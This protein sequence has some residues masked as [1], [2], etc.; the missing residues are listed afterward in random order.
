MATINTPAG[1]TRNGRNLRILAD[2]AREISTGLGARRNTYGTVQLVTV[3]QMHEGAN[4]AAHVTVKYRDG[5]IGQACFQDVTIAKQWAHGF[6]TRRGGQ[7]QYQP[8]G[9]SAAV[10][11]C[12]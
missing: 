12:N 11:R 5:A 2:Y 8:R 6:A 3:E 9:V 4:Y 10:F 7:A 1:K